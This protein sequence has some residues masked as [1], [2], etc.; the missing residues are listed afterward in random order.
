MPQVQIFAWALMATLSVVPAWA[1]TAPP[2][3][4]PRRGQSQTAASA[5]TAGVST[6][7]GYIIGAD[8]L[9]SIRFWGDTQ[10]SADVVVRPDGKI[11]LSLLNDVP[12]A[13]L[14]PE[15]LADA[16]E[17][18]ASK[19][20][21]EPDASVIVR[22]IRSRRVFVMG[23]GI[24]KPGVVPLNTEMNV[25]QVIAASGGLLEYADKGNVLIIRNENGRERRFKFNFD[26]VVKGKNPGQ[27]IV[28]QPGDT[29]YVK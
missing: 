14:T 20:V 25:L 2:S 15:Q 17:K 18:A 27:N 1:Q 4:S 28:L 13:G 23:Q 26:D 21:T 24:A 6:P 16:L 7:P 8:D 10:L 29:V 9:L 11:S 3:E 5:V 22:E 12:A 19:F